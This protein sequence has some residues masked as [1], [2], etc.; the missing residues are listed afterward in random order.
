MPFQ[1]VAYTSVLMCTKGT[2]QG[3][4]VTHGSYVFYNSGLIKRRIKGAVKTHIRTDLNYKSVHIRVPVWYISLCSDLS[5][6]LYSNMHDYEWLISDTWVTN[7]T[8]ELPIGNKK[9][10]EVIMTAS[11]KQNKHNGRIWATHNISDNWV[12]NQHW[13][14]QGLRLDCNV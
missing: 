1:C 14:T 6:N 9:H 11:N 12:T 3:S 5:N 2:H 4:L 10:N 8:I 13:K 7:L